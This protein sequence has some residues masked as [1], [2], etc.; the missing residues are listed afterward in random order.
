MM[1]NSARQG[2]TE[3]KPGMGSGKTRPNM[4]SNQG[5]GTSESTGKFA[6]GGNSN[7][8]QK[9]S[10][11]LRKKMQLGPNDKLGFGGKITTK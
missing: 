8:P 9:I 2:N 1:N 10:R 6:L 5:P 7:S 4:Q 3:K 11:K